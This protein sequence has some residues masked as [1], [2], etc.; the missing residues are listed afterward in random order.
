M[1]CY[2]LIGAGSAVFT[3][4]LLADL[5]NAGESCEVR[6]VDPNPVAL[7]VAHGL[8]RKMIAHSHVAIT[9]RASTDR[10][11]LLP[12]ATV[13]ICTV[14]VGGRR[15]W[16]QDVFIPRKYGIYV[17]VG[18]TIGPGGSSRAVRM[19][20][21][22]LA[23]ANDVADL[24]PQALFFNYSNPMAPIC[25][26]I[27][28]HAGINVIGLCHGVLH[29]T[30]Y[31]A[32]QLGVAWQE[33]AVTYAGY[34]H[35]TW[36]TSVRHPQRDLD[37]ELKALAVRHI[38]H[39]DDNPFSWHLYQLTGAFPAVLDRHVCEFFPQFFRTGAYYR[40]QRLGVEAFSFEETIRSGDAEFVAMQ[41]ESLPST[42]LNADIFAR[43]S[44]EHEQVVD[45]VKAIRTAQPT[46]FAANL[47]NQG[48]VAQLPSG[49]IVE[50]PAVAKSG[51][52]VPA[53]PVELPVALAGMLASRYAWVETIVAA[54][55]HADQAAFQH[56]LI[57][58]GYADSLSQVEHMG[59]E[60]WQHTRQFC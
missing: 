36:M 19:I 34:N 44:G 26:A 55:V 31:L 58:D 4:G 2:V 13:V 56:A 7:A 12:G 39:Q 16:E 24:A 5:I 3:R 47:P 14:G 11:E 33:L 40:D 57:I 38:A 18:D 50:A 48:Q 20:P 46:L 54:A 37:A 6:L 60:L 15:A 43:E 32:A 22:M 35:L 23:I 17:P 27:H 21:A 1:E 9:V 25:H 59:R 29:V 41:H 10:R 28:H 53:G 8:A 52:L 30:H 42:P 45:I 49:A 51:Q